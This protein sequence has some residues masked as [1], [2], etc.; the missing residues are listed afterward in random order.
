M[1]EN[2]RRRI[3]ELYRESVEENHDYAVD[4]IVSRIVDT[5]DF[6][7]SPDQI[8]Y[9]ESV[10]QSLHDQRARY[11]ATDYDDVVEQSYPASD[12]PPIP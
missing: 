11:H 8:R 12:P 4:Q 5:L 7:R 2:D 6:G 9:V 1:S 10:V 3:E